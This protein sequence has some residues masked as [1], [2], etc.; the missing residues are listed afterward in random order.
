[1]HQDLLINFPYPYMLNNIKIN[2]FN[3]EWPQVCKMCKYNS[4]EYS[5]NEYHMC[6]RGVFYKWYSK[7][8]MI[9]GFVLKERSMTTRKSALIIK[10]NN[11]YEVS[12]KDIDL[13]MQNILEVQN[14]Y[15]KEYS[16][17]IDVAVNERIQNLLDKYNIKSK[18]LDQINEYL[19]SMHDVKQFVATIIGNI[20]CIISRYNKGST[21]ENLNYSSEYEKAIYYSCKIIEAKINTLLYVKNLKIID[22]SF[23]V[24]TSIHQLIV[25]IIRIYQSLF[26]ERNI[27]I[28]IYEFYETIYTDYDSISIIPHTI[29]DNALKYSPEGSNFI[30]SFSSNLDTISIDFESLGPKI[31]QHERDIIFQMGFRGE[32]AQKISED[33]LGFGLYAL[34]QILNKLNGDISLWQ[35]DNEDI[36]YKGYYR[37]IFTVKLPK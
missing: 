19:R 9:G 5:D 6:P 32:N 8:F 3:F 24:K 23:F 15:K 28:N 37:T 16:D 27:H 17:I 22:R 25:K 34:K 1:M 18:E 26:K 14:I 31:F 33:G 35:N 29:I 7:N 30:I 21:E 4:C 10:N 2:G 36:S 20:N 11:K 12:K 13:A